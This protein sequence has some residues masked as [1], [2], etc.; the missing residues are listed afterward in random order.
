ML[1]PAK[2]FI[3]HIS[4]EAELASEMKQ[5]L[6]DDFGTKVGVF[7]SSDLTS[8]LAGAKWLTASEA[9]LRETDIML[10]LC[11][12]DSIERPWIQ[13]ESGMAWMKN[14]P[15]IPICYSG[16][17][18][19]DLSMPLSF[20]QATDI[21][22]KEGVI[23]LYRRIEEA[24]N[25][26]L[27]E[28]AAVACHGRLRPI[29]DAFELA[30]DETSIQRAWRNLR[31]W[32]F[33]GLAPIS[34]VSIYAL[35][36]WATGGDIKVSGDV[37]S[38]AAVVCSVSFGCFFQL[39]R[40]RFDFEILGLSALTVGVASGVMSLGFYYRIGSEPSPDF[41]STYMLRIFT[42]L[43]YVAASFL[44]GAGIGRWLQ[45]NPRQLYILTRVLRFW[46]RPGQ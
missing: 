36:L 35:T 14:I 33:V 7:V 19:A 4:E 32:G 6:L 21:Q 3:S 31:G 5:C 23:R 11:S 42:F 16:L 18:T 40:E 43:L 44:A 22:E 10:V 8:I 45:R 34:I 2:V 20:L 38:I 13:F 39:C 17:K 30:R 1:M 15:I 12:P 25:H 37:L 28:S 9:A 26:H 41:F 27:S 29:A 46:R 24:T